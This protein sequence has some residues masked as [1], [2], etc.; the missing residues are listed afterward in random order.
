MSWYPTRK[1]CFFHLNLYKIIKRIGDTIFFRSLLLILGWS[2]SSV[3]S[4]FLHSA[5]LPF[6]S[7]ALCR[8]SEYTN[9]SARNL[10]FPDNVWSRRREITLADAVVGCLWSWLK[11]TTKTNYNLFWTVFTFEFVSEKE[12]C[13]AGKCWGIHSVP[14]AQWAAT[15]GAAGWALGWELL[16]LCATKGLRICGPARGPVAWPGDLQPNQGTGHSETRQEF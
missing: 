13:P 14:A 8:L 7:P 2:S 6:M 9:Y 11:K 1:F 5:L 3:V 16:T 15:V 4:W 10:L 12:V